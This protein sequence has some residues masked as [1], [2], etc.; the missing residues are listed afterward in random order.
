MKVPG[1]G[2][3]YERVPGAG[4]SFRMPKRLMITDPESEISGNRIPRESANF[5]S[6]VGGS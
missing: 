5:L 2:T 1:C 3:P 6:V 4:S